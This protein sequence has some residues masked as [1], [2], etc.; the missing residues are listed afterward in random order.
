[1]RLIPASIL[2]IALAAPVAAKPPLR[3]VAEI[4]N[5]LMAIAIADEIRK[6]CDD[7]QPRMIRAITQINALEQKAR[8]LGYSKD[9]IDDY[10]TS[11]SEKARMRK[12]AESW[13]VSKGVNP[14]DRGALCQFGR[15]EI[16]R[17][18]A[19]GYFLR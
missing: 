3:E 19:I 1:M 5:G 2:L 11:K 16:A 18:G 6:S 4:D 13:L 12:K 9:E 17:G 8:D 7:I 14:N 10:V 15:D